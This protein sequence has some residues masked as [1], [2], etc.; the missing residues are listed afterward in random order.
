MGRGIN[1]IFGRLVMLSKVRIIVFS[2]FL[3]IGIF[4][5]QSGKM[6]FFLCDSS[7]IFLVFFFSL[8]CII[9]YFFLLILIMFE[10]LA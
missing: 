2:L 9:F 5:F 6:K 4:V 10:I 8:C 3:S 1:V 7:K